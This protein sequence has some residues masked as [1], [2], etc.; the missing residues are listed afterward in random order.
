MKLY[1]I[2]LITL[3]QVFGK[4]A[5]QKK[6]WKALELMRF[7]FR[8][9]DQLGLQCLKKKLKLKHFIKSLENRELT[10]I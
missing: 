7:L 2:A 5:K 10:V 6:N 4:R 8:A 3:L 1:R 9:A